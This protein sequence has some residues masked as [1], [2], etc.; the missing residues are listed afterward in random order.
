MI[1]IVAINAL[2]LEKISV[3]IF[4]IIGVKERSKLN[5]HTNPKAKGIT[6]N[7]SIYRDN[8][9]DVLI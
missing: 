2:I 4:E 1:L 5:F 6:S 3:A 8:K 7:Q 9:N